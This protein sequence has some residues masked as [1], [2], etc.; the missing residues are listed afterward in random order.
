MARQH[1]HLHLNVQR[2]MTR[3]Q[4]TAD[5][6]KAFTRGADT[7]G[8][9]EMESD[10][11]H[12]EFWRLARVHGY[13]GHLPALGRAGSALALAVKTTYGAIIRRKV[14][15][16]AIGLRKVSPNRYLAQMGIIRFEDKVT[17]DLGEHHAYS[18]GWTGSKSLD[19]LRQARWYIG[20]RVVR[21][22]ERGATKN[23]DIV[24]GGGDLN[25]PPNTWKGGKVLPGLLNP[26]GMLTAAYAHTDA[27]HGRTTFDYVW[28]LSAKVTARFTADSTPAFASDHDGI[29][30]TVAW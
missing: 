2:T 24:I 27:T 1:T 10:W 5:L 16:A 7:V 15:F 13:T 6:E 4:I 12:S 18:S 11:H 3:A 19:A 29:L 28:C 22:A 9:C 21:K 23:A 25:R 14:T 8:L 26:K 30:A 20:M 17:V